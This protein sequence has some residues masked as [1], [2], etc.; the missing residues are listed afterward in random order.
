MPTDYEETESKEALSVIIEAGMDD[1][2]QVVKENPGGVKQTIRIL[3]N[4]PDNFN[5]HSPNFTVLK[6]ARQILFGID[7]QSRAEQRGIEAK[8]NEVTPEQLARRKEIM[9][10]P[11]FTARTHKDHKRLHT[12]WL[13]TFKPERNGDEI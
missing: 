1:F 7:P 2:R 4:H 12:E 5:T 10:L 13:G 9:A 11:E 6:E 8:A 3:G